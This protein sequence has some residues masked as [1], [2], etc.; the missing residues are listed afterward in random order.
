MGKLMSIKSKMNYFIV[1]ITLAITLATIFVYWSMSLISSQYTYLHK[2]AMMGALNTITIE[3]N[4]NYISRT[5]R[6]ILLGGDFSNN[7]TKLKERITSINN[8]F[9]ELEIMMK[10]DDSLPIVKNARA[11]T[12]LF[13]SQ[14][15]KMMES[16]NSNDIK[17]KKD[18]LYKKYK[19]ELTPYANKSRISFKKLVTYKEKE[20]E[21]HSNNLGSELNWFKYSILIFGLIFAAI[22]LFTA[23]II[24]NYVING[25]ENFSRHISRASEG[26]FSSDIGH[27]NSD[28]TTELG[29]MGNAL[30][31]LIEQISTT[32]GEINT[33]IVNAS[34]GDFSKKISS[35]NLRGEFVNAIENVS[36]SIDFMQTQHQKSRRDEFNSKLSHKST[37]VSESLSVIQKDLAQNIDDLKTVTSATKSASDLANDSMENIEVIVDELNTLNEQV[38]TNNSSIMELASQTQN[39]T[40]VIEL[41][42]DIADQTNLLALNAAIEAARA[43]EHGRGFAVVA[44]EVR[45]LAERTHK[46]TGEISI[47]IKSLQQGM[48][49]IQVSSESM[50]ETVDGSTQ[51]IGEFEGTLVELSDNSSTIV[52]NSIFVVLAKIEHILYKYRAYSS[53]MTLKQV[54]P[55]S[56][57]NECELGKWYNNEGKR[58]FEKTQSYPKMAVPHSIVHDNAN[59]NLQYLTESA[60][61]DTLSNATNIIDNFDFMEKA[62]EELFALLD[63]ILVES[64][65]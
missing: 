64:K 33:S 13:L 55:S 29:R 53:V 32:V 41:I 9:N 8:N 26:D 48:S 21:K 7:I 19:T 62:S 60:D 44:D 12:M 40:S 49:E 10:G 57:T 23:S 46:A 51:K 37:Q 35:N 39:I 2:N 27:T 43:G 1:S 59:K 17:N 50:R 5:S 36:K 61:V 20:L 3:K 31:K 4:L 65:N 6:D 11:S 45:K 58:R 14:S 24:K 42:T 34:K 28:D 52:N 15:L 22:I 30:S 63:D 16:L 18:I 25:I 54:L 47:S 56:S 38:S